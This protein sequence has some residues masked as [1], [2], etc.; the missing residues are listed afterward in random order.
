ME[1]G[2]EVILSKND[3]SVVDG[4]D[5]DGPD[6]EDADEDDGELICCLG[7]FFNSSFIF[8]E[9]D[10][11][12][13]S[14]KVFDFDDVIVLNIFSYFWFGVV[15]KSFIFGTVNVDLKNEIKLWTRKINITEIIEI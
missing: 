4:A 8:V 13:S 14:S 11:T 10:S 7:K 3:I 5:A 15:T 6:D 2:K 9:G 12:K 1:F